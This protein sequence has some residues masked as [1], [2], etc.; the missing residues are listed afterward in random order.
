MIEFFRDKLDGPIY[1]II[2]L[3]SLFL[4]MAIIGF[5]MEKQKMERDEKDKIAH[6]KEIITPINPIIAESNEVLKEVTPPSINGSNIETIDD[7]LE[8]PV[9]NDE[10]TDGLYAKPNVIIFEDPDEKKE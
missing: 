3:I 8:I 6:V 9:S 5:I 2:A 4:I 1:I 10:V 7:N